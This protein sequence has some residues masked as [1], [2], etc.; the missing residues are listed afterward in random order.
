MPYKNITVT[1]TKYSSQHTNKTNQFYVGFNTQDTT[2][3]S[4]KM[5]DFDLIKQDLLNRFNTRRGERV[6]NP[7]FGT[8]IWDLIYEPLTPAVKQQI[9]DDLNAILNADLRA[10][11]T[12]INIVQADAGFLIEVTLVL[13]GTDV[14]QTLRFNF[15]SAVG[16]ASA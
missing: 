7:N 10:S 14:S 1:P 12:Q 11:P 6:M 3:K 4:V 15:D 2:T 5:Y 16:L 9:T 13:N 8:I